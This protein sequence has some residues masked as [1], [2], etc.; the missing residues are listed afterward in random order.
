MYQGQPSTD[1]KTIAS[2]YFESSF[3]SVIKV[4]FIVGRDNNQLG[5]VRGSTSSSNAKDI[6]SKIKDIQEPELIYIRNQG[7]LDRSITI[8]TEGASIATIVSQGNTLF[9]FPSW[10]EAFICFH[11]L[12]GTSIHIVQIHQRLCGR[13]NNKIQSE[14]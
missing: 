9:I 2:V 4:R 5:F 14:A 13:T 12:K 3:K 11:V 1:M 10:K 8:Y 6:L 7:A